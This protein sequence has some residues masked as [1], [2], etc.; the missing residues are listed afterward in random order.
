MYGGY[1]TRSALLARAARTRRIP[2]ARSSPHQARR[3]LDV[4]RSSDRGRVISLALPIVLLLTLFA[5]VSSLGAVPSALMLLTALIA[6]DVAALTVGHD[7]RDGLDWRRVPARA[8][9]VR[10]NRT[11]RVGER[12]R[13]ESHR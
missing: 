13:D 9:P 1:G 12:T 4:V 5:T 2:K 10:S 11:G 7:S 3:A 8:A 6:L